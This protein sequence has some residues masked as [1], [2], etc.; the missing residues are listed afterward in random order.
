M[1]FRSLAGTRI[2]ARFAGRDRVLGPRI[3]FGMLPQAGIALA[4][5]NL[6]RTRFGAW[7]EQL[8][9]LVL[10][11]VVVNEMV[12]PI[13]WRTALARAGEIGKREQAPAAAAP[14]AP[15]DAATQPAE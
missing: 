8:G 1:L 3:F 11:T 4:L 12:G 7:G 6:V 15:P 13:A 5:A 9:T 2:G 10:G 14:D